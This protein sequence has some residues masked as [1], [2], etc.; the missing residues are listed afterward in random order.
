M[1]REESVNCDV[2][3]VGSGAGGMS[4]AIAARL[5]GLSVIIAE[6][7]GKFG[8]TT[9]QSGGYLWIPCNPLAARLGVVD[10]PEAAYEYIQSEAANHFD[11][12]CAR[13]FLVNG[14]RMVEFF[15]EKTA[16]DFVADP[17]YPD[18]HP[19]LPGGM[20]GGRWLHSAPF[21]GHELGAE[22]ARLNSP[23]P[24]LT[25]LGMAIMKSEFT[26]FL[27][28][29]RS[30]R[31]AALVAKRII[32]HAYDLLFHGRSTYLVNGRAL[33]AR[34]AKS[35]LDL[36]IP[37]WLSSPVQEIIIED[38]A[39]KGA[40][41]SKEGRR[42][43][44]RT[45][46][47]IVLA[48]GGFPRDAARRTTLDSH[49]VADNGQFSIAAPGDTGDGLRLA[50]NAGG[51]V[52]EGFPNTV[53]WVPVSRM[54]RS[55][56]RIDLFPHTS[57]VDRFKPGFIAVMPDGRRFVNEADPD[58]D[59]VQAM[60]RAADGKDNVEAFIV[61][62]HRALRRYG[63]G[64]VKPFPLPLFPYLRAGYLLK[65]DTIEELAE[66]AGID[67]ATLGATIAAFNKD[68]D[69][70]KDLQFGKGSTVYNRFSGDPDHKPN[71]CVAALNRPPFYAVKI[72]PG[73]VGTHAGLKTDGNAQVVR[74]DG[75]PVRG[76]YAVG[77]DMANIVGNSSGSTL[78]PAMVFGYIAGRHLAGIGGGHLQNRQDSLVVEN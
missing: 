52:I 75:Q 9:A 42:T 43:H 61:C 32:R 64:V 15:R 26:H 20:E 68:A 72:F 65:G 16:V 10:T 35:A 45:S 56:G 4:A 67:R 51:Y 21:S 17:T 13:A 25:F 37:L 73:D 27:N 29:M 48:C 60:F 28:A 36:G 24:V 2:L 62:D 44:V 33:V 8:G 39:V 14:K 50:E 1:R 34:L 22:L 69:Q 49:G 38:G 5:E 6:K 77:N 40:I 31:S 11:P 46:R 30:F 57:R 78:G 18:Y 12:E 66:R 71:S 55:D 41:V 63:L 7:D 23:L 59:V 53:Y 58:F 76:L 54:N 3:V 74:R 19:D 47:G 70:G